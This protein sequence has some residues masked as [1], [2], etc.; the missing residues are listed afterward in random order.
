MEYSYDYRHAGELEKDQAPIRPET[1]RSRRAASLIRLQS[2]AGAIFFGA[3]LLLSWNLEGLFMTEITT[4][5]VI[6]GLIG[7]IRYQD[8][9]ASNDTDQNHL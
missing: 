3:L 4:V 1:I 5:A 2:L 6:C 7:L 8:A 9:T